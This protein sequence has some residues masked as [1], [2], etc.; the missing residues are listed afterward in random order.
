VH[1]R[2]TKFGKDLA[3][4]TSASLGKRKKIRALL[5]MAENLYLSTWRRKERTSLGAST[6]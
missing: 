1:E 4:L 2:R 6:I 3:I 5:K